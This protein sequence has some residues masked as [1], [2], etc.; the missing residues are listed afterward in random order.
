MDAED[1]RRFIREHHRA[2]LATI[3]SDGRPQLSP[4]TTA[5]D[6][7]GRAVV[8]TRAGAM[9]TANVR[10]QRWA[11]LCVMSDQF[12]GPWVQVE[13]PTDVL[14]LPEAMEELVAYYRSISGEHPD[15]DD[16]RRAMERERRL[17]LRITI[18][19]AGPNRAG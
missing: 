15:W 16:Y 14:E 3:R 17:L 18:E 6:S 13:G 2:V 10:R 8:S 5:I 4:V 9:K 19:R 12:F 7:Q 11:A 1:A